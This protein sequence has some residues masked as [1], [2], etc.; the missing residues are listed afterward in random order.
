MNANLIATQKMA[1]TAAG[2]ED[3]NP[4]QGCELNGHEH[5]RETIVALGSD[6]LDRRGTDAGLGGEQ[7]IELAYPLDIGIVASGID[8]PAVAHNVIDD[9]ETAPRR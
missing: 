6:G 4:S 5:D 1:A 7:L 2:Q 3:G 9:D 8:Y